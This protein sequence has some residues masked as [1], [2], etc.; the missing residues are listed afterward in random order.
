[1]TLKVTLLVTLKMKTANHMESPR[2]YPAFNSV[3][4]KLITAS[5]NIRRTR[6]Q[7]LHM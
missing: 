6:T 3:T 4:M 7:S 5:I 1:M 2:L